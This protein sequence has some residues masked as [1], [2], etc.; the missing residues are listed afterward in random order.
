MG[1][2]KSEFEG[3]ASKM[4]EIVTKYHDTLNSR[5]SFPSELK[6]GKYNYNISKQKYWSFLNFDKNNWFY[7]AFLL[8]F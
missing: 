4:I 7:F 5:E 2:T 8:K 1:L 6:F 3:A